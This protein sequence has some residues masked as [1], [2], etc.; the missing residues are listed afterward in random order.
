MA[1][2]QNASG[3]SPN[4]PSAKLCL[5][6][7]RRTGGIDCTTL[8]EEAVRCSG[9]VDESGI[10]SPGLDRVTDGWEGVLHSMRMA[11]PI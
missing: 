1:K 6:L 7:V 2:P 9:H 8:G 3:G 5:F 10:E 4:S 11:D